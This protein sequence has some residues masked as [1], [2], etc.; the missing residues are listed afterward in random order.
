M[1]HPASS[2]S[3]APPG[4]DLHQ[5]LRLVKYFV[6]VVFVLLFVVYSSSP[7]SD[8]LRLLPLFDNR[9]KPQDNVTIE[10]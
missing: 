10:L 2:R 3:Q 9:F 8:A 1:H 5:R 4:N 7:R 6:F